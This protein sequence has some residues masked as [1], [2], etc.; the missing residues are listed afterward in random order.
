MK[1]VQVTITAKQA[2][3]G[4]I[5]PYQRHIRVSEL[6]I[7]EVPLYE[8]RIEPGLTFKAI[9]F[10]LTPQTP[11]PQ[12]RHCNNGLNSYHKTIPTWVPGYSPH[13]YVGIGRRGAWR[14]LDGKEFLLHEGA[15]PD[16]GTVGGSLGCIEIVKGSEWNRFLASLEQVSGGTCEQISSAHSMTLVIEAAPY[17]VARLFSRQPVGR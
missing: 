9:R 11:A 8:I 16:E 5:Y 10:G 2:G 1:P 13:S 12:L 3:K 14:I 4:Y 17:P 6:D 15:D 7:Y